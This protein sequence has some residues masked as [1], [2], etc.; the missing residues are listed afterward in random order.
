M[1]RPNPIRA[2]M[3][4]PLPSISYQKRR[5]FRVGPEDVKYAYKIINRY[6]FDNQLRMP[7]MSTGITRDYW[8]MCIGNIHAQPTG[9]YCTI[10]LSDK[11][12]CPQWFMNVVAH[13]MAHQYQW[14][15]D[16]YDRATLGLEPIMSHGP[17][18]FA[19]RDRFDHYGLTLKTAN[20][21]KR[22]FAHQDFHKC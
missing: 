7:E 20:G 21:Q 17:T 16:R 19:W 14:D 15:I 11:W 18:F 1:A 13:E 8:G 2:I 12:F 10:K 4:A 3:A 9:S 6:V 5:G 22:W